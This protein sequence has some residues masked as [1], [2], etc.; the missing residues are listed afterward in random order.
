MREYWN[1]DWEFTTVYQE[2][3]KFIDYPDNDL[4]IVRLPHTNV[5]TPY[6]CF[7]SKLYEEVCGYRKR[8]VAPAKWEGKRILITFEGAAHE[9]TVFINGQEVYIHR[10]GYTAF[11][12]ELT[13]YIDIGKENIL[14]VRLNTKESIN[15]PPFGNIIDYMTYGG[16][17]RE[18]YVEIKEMEYIKD[19][20]LSTR[21]VEKPVKELRIQTTLNEDVNERYLEHI[22]CELDGTVIT[23]FE[24]TTDRDT[25]Y[26]VEGVSLW[27][28]ESPKRYVLISR[29]FHGEILLDEYQV[30]FGFR[31]A[32]FKK[33][34]FY[35]NGKKLKIRGL[36]RHQS[37]P[38]VGYAMPK[39]VQRN[40]VDI[41][42]DELGVNAV[43]TSHYPQ[44][45]EFIDYCDERGLLVFTEIPGWQYI[46]DEA[47]KTIACKNVEEMVLQYRNHPSIILWGVRINESM[48][49]DA[50]YIKTNS[51]AHRLDHSR[52]TG[53]VRFIQ[54][55]NLLEDVYTY[56]DFIHNG[57]NIGVSKKRSVTSD[58]NKGYL[59]S[60]Y[61][62]HMFPVKSFDKE[63]VRL[64]HA[65]RHANVMNDYYK[66]EDIAGGFG[67]CMFDYNTHQDFGSGD[68]ICYH[69]VLDMFRNPKLAA[70]V[71]RS[72]TD[73][74][75]VLEISSSMDIGEHPGGNIGHIYAFTNVDSV[76]VYKNNCFVKEFYP[77]QKWF[78]HMI[79]PP[80]HIDDLV[81]ERLEKEEHLDKKTAE[82]I[83][84]IL[85]AV[86]KYGVN[87]LPIRYKIK[88]FKIM[89]FKKMT[90]E[91]GM[92]LF[93]K[94]VSNW[95]GKVTSFRFDGMKDGKVVISVKK[96]PIAAN[97]LEVITD[98]TE[99]VEDRSYD[100]A[101]IRIRMK[102]Q[103]GNIQTYYQE[104]VM[105]E[106]SKELTLIGP[107]LLSLKGGMAGTYVKT[108]GNSGTAK[109]RITTMDGQ[110]AELDYVIKKSTV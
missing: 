43:R 72:Q 86:L 6:N 83:K 104:P 70:S 7:Q 110:Q 18:V 29:L 106:V 59:I 91:D 28:T 12:V 87:G 94:Y 19:V 93:N 10:C 5:T 92:E 13:E 68:G 4:E 17:Y 49:D 105:I 74:S 25:T 108:N 51:I 84:S 9:A 53:G 63:S 95:G 22:L 34:G 82:E 45:Q 15:Q 98:T 48:D 90:F 44:S 58:M 30:V 50:F 54:K 3:F 46:G 35:L 33:D 78:K 99:L 60:E 101:S 96:E 71:Y 36:N 11:T 61:N 79:H 85:F 24:Q 88:L 52:Q 65:L 100:V 76:R 62:G 41:L 75:P 56:N 32:V 40:D 47:W 2:E 1:D 38:Y 97:K 81:G 31:E 8:F 103:N 102:D 107:K 57:R 69:G 23:R 67:W 20:F 42:I 89:I 80:I 14:A 66:E 27:S 21:E 64:E 55:S 109:V 73:C 37:Y 26:Q 77:E 39:R 16:L